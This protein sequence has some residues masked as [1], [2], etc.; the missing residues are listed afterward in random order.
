MSSHKLPFGL[1][2][3]G[4]SVILL[5]LVNRLLLLGYVLVVC[6]WSITTAV[7]LMEIIII[8]L[9]CPIVS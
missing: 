1:I 5:L 2:F 6:H 3:E 4:A 8:L 7:P 9:A